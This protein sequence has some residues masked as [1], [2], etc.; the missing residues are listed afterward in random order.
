MCLNFTFVALLLA[1]VVGIAFAVSLF[2]AMRLK[3]LVSVWGIF[4]VIASNGGTSG[5]KE[6]DKKILPYRVMAIAASILSFFILQQF[7]SLDCSVRDEPRA[8]SQIENP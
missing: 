5:S 2:A 7:V 1:T 8:K 4:S 6:I 3:G